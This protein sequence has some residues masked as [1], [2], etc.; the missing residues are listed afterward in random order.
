MSEYSD[1]SQFINQSGQ[2]SLLQSIQ[3]VG[4]VF[5]ASAVVD[6]QFFVLFPGYDTAMQIGKVG[7]AYPIRPDI[8]KQLT[9]AVKVNSG[10][11]DPGPDSLQI[12]WF[13]DSRLNG[14]G[15]VWGYSRGILLHPEA[16][17]G[18]PNPVWKLYRID[19][20]SSGVYG[21]DPLEWTQ[22]LGRVTP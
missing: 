5:S 15:G 17:R 16:D 4:G 6:A 9:L 19:L 20:S 14:P 12:F 2:A 13:A 22:C 10:P 8:Y 7:H 3:V 21:R 1:I 18:I 11:P